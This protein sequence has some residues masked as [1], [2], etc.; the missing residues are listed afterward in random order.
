MP[1][2]DQFETEAYTSYSGS[3]TDRVQ[4]GNSYFYNEFTLANA[5]PY[6]T[7]RK[8]IALKTTGINESS[9]SQVD[10]S[11]ADW[12]GYVSGAYIP[13]RTQ[14]GNVKLFSDN[15]L[16]Y[17]SLTPS[18]INIIKINNQQTP[19]L[20]TTSSWKQVFS[21]SL[22][23][24]T[25][26]ERTSL[27]EASAH[28]FL[29]AQG[30]NIPVPNALNNNQLTVPINS[31]AN[32]AW[33]YQ[34]PFQSKFKRIETYLGSGLNNLSIETD[35]YSSSFYSPPFQTNK[36]GSL[37]YAYGDGTFKRY[38]QYSQMWL[39][40][41][42]KISLPSNIAHK[43]VYIKSYN[44]LQKIYVSN[45]SGSVNPAY[46][47]FGENGTILTSS[48][49]MSHT[50]ETISSIHEIPSVVAPNALDLPIEIDNWPP[51]LYNEGIGIIPSYTA[52]TGSIRDALPIAYNSALIGTDGSH[53]QW[54]LIVEAID[55]N[56]NRRGKLVRTKSSRW[57]NK[58]PSRDD[59]ELVDLDKEFNMGAT[60]AT[61][62][63]VD[64]YSFSTKNP[65]GQNI[66]ST[67]QQIFVVGKVDGYDEFGTTRT[68]TALI[69][70]GGNDGAAAYSSCAANTFTKNAAGQADKADTIW[71]STTG[72]KWNDRTGTFPYS[73]V[74]GLDCSTLSPTG[75]GYMARS[76]G[77]NG[78][79]TTDSYTQINLGNVWTSAVDVP[80]LYSIAYSHISGALG[81]GSNRTVLCVGARGTILKNTNGGTSSGD[82]LKK[83]PDNGYVGT[84]VDV[85]KV[86]SLNSNQ[87]LEAYDWVV[88]GDDGEIQISD[89]DGNT[90]ISLTD[91]GAGI[92]YPNRISGSSGLGNTIYNS[93]TYGSGSKNVVYTTVNRNNSF[94][95]YYA[96][97][98]E[99]SL[100]TNVV[101]IATPP[102]TMA[103]GGVTTHD[104]NENQFDPP[105]TIPAVS[106]DTVLVCRLADVSGTNSQYVNDFIDQY[107]FKPL[108]TFN[109]SNNVFIKPSNSDFCKSFFGYGDGFSLDLTEYQYGNILN[110]GRKGKTPN[111]LDWS[112]YDLYGHV[113][114]PQ[115]NLYGPQIRGWKYG[116]YSGINVSTNAIYRRG[117]YGQFRDRLEQ[118]I[119]TKYISLDQTNPYS[120]PL[121]FDKRTVDGPINVAFI[122]GT[123]IYSQSIDY[124]T[125]TN[126]D[127]NPYDSGIYDYEYRSGQPFFD[128][129]NE[130]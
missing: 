126:P 25:V 33:L 29:T 96:G 11:R 117:R 26:L 76:F 122:T 111:F 67:I 63:D 49:G 68:T 98:I 51:L 81:L 102:Y 46:I 74:C 91:N 70:V 30:T 65:A 4:Y 130:D 128:R 75:S 114:V 47:A 80:P 28:I 44:P 57:G 56:G 72:G 62:I 40:A 2:F 94:R 83:T 55:S 100:V 21:A 31:F 103:V 124:V 41:G 59:W 78:T 27:E 120:Y 52:A 69:G 127:Y 99:K 95:S 112:P 22:N 12:L 110:V 60:G 77:S 34:Y 17:N 119:F 71:F 89:D 107:V 19:Y 53:L 35:I 7:N 50:W 38:T 85:K 84:F 48:N 86:Y 129:G 39:G 18:P 90:W 109:N 9:F 123:L 6:G 23:V 108:T 88:V 121:N 14:N 106:Y 105:V 93:Q 43:H 54:L 79:A 61:P 73:W 3:Y 24:S 1:I 13:S 42:S 45:Y 36:L 20:N 118:R 37:F 5:N 58:I 32:V 113:D 87:G 116:L 92:D 66:T 64:L 82:W 115:F 15:E 8:T 125:A 101:N 104:F 10:L 16:I 97:S